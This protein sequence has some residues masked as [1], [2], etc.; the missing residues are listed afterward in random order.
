MP[1]LLPYNFIPRNYQIAMLTAREKGYKREVYVLH[2]R[3]GKDLTAINDCARAIMQRPGI[4]YY[5]FPTFA[6]ARKV[7]WDGMTA[8]GRKFISYFPQEL[9]KSTNAT[10][11]KIEFVNGSIFQIIGT[12]NF[13]CYDDKTEILTHQGWKLFKDISENEIVATLQ[14]NSLVYTQISK[15]VEYDYDGAMYHVQSK[16]IDLLTTPEHKYYV[17]SRKGIRKFRKIKDINDY[18]DKIPATCQWEGNHLDSFTLPEIKRSNFDRSQYQH[19]VFKIED[20]CA[21]MGIFLSEG[22][23]YC[24]KKDYRV[25]IS[26]SN[27][28]HPKIVEEI[29]NLLNRMCLHFYYDSHNFLI[30]N[31]QLYEY[32]KQFGKC[33]EKY[34]P[35][36]LLE[37]SPKYLTILKDWLIKGDGYIQKGGQEL[38]YST[39]KQLIDDFQEL[40][41]KLGLSG[42]IR[43]KEQSVGYIKD[44]KINSTKTIYALCIRKSKYKY[45][46]KTKS[47]YI[48]KEHYT[49]KIYCVDV[50]NHVIKVRRNGFEVWCGNSIRGTNCIGAI[51][52]EY[53]QQD[54]RAWETIEPILL[55]NGGWAK[56]LYTPN[57]KNH[58]WDLYNFAKSDPDWFTLLLTINE[59][60]KDDGT[61][62]ITLDQINALRR[63]GVSEE[64]IQQEY[65]CSFTMGTEGAYYAKLMEEARQKGR[66]RRVP[67][68][69]TLP[70]HTAWDIGVSDFTSIIFFQKAFNEYHHIDYYENQGEGLQ[71]YARILQSKA[72]D[73]KYFYGNHYVPHDLG[74]R[75]FSAEA[76]TVIE[77]ARQLGL[78]FQLVPK[79]AIHDGIQSCRNLIPKSYFDNEKCK[80][81]INHL[82]NY[83]KAFNQTMKVWMDT[84]K[85]DEHSH[86]CDAFRIEAM[87]EKSSV[88][89]DPNN[90][91][92]VNAGTEYIRS[93]SNP[94][95][96]Y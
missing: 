78:R 1:I 92:Y 46:R 54:P 42:N 79:H 30:N 43:I 91:D 95:S 71:F 93:H 32:L 52:S 86:G 48:S 53:A 81:L 4:Y 69:N 10:E 75:V 51:F 38:Y 28:A 67:F 82:D 59:T 11:M 55:E 58:G 35:R 60:R 94:F 12:D 76:K 39:S 37:L 57:G 63:R 64:F 47:T 49:G 85:H 3:A 29:K 62:V 26:Q 84:P 72:M 83:T 14:D 74:A 65:Y 9:I 77:V 50:P 88:V 17:Q 80:L 66:I 25:Y 19:Q 13:D 89:Y 22:S 27:A 5:L 2:R 40:I 21:F 56:F 7:V 96:G 31:K 68:D 73:E 45:F 18:N 8:E 41:I 24:G 44:R 34:I 36:D 33:D 6:Q 16:S 15:K 23:V 70:V 90:T 20:W 87:A 61:P